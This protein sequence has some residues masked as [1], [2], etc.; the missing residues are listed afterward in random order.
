MHPDRF[1]QT[2]QR[3]EWELA[4]E[5]LKELNVAYDALKDPV[6]RR[7]YDATLD[8]GTDRQSTDTEP[9]A[10]SPSNTETR[11]NS[12]TENQRKDTDERPRKSRASKPQTDPKAPTENKRKNALFRVVARLC[13]FLAVVILLK[14]FFG[15]SGEVKKRFASAK[16]AEEERVAAAERAEEQRIAAEER[17]E[18]ARIAAE[19]RAEKER[20]AAAE[21]AEK[22]RAAAAKR[23]YE[24]EIAAAETRLKLERDHIAAAR[25]AE[26]EKVAAVEASLKRKKFVAALLSMTEGGFQ[27]NLTQNSE[28][29][30]H[31]QEVKRAMIE[32]RKRYPAIGIEGSDQ[33]REYVEVYEEL[34]KLRPD[35]FSKGDW[36]IRLVELVAKREG[37]ERAAE[38]K[39]GAGTESRELPLPR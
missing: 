36:P 18:K 19:K 5:M 10:A 23:A 15:L 17:E 28:T 11:Q 4:N 2:K 39:S 21:R 3:A 24:D 7:D 37:W 32:A 13:A 20:I 26:E 25:R 30:V 9:Q 14:Q 34:N 16:R 27:I 22:E 6:S 38:P 29:P 12:A 31:S 33:N 35:I 1:S 8:R